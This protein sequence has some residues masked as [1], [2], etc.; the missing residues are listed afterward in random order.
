M[1][2]TVA[3]LIAQVGADLSQ[4]RIGMNEVDAR[5]RLT[6]IRAREADARVANLRARSMV[7]EE[8][9]Q[10]AHQARLTTIARQP[11]LEFARQTAETRLADAQTRLAAAHHAATSTPLGAT[12]R[13][14]T[15]IRREA[16]AATNAEE[17]A[18]TRLQTAT[19]RLTRSQDREMD[20]A[21]R[22][23]ALR[24]ASAESARR[25][26][27]VDE[28]GAA[29]REVARRY[30]ARLAQNAQ[31]HRIR[32]ANAVAAV[33]EKA[34]LI[35]GGGLIVASK[36]GADFNQ[37]LL[38]A[39]HNTSL[40]TAGIDEMNTAVKRLGIESGADMEK[41]ADGFR[42]IENRGYS[43]RQSTEILTQSMKGA[44]A[45]GS[46]LSA[47][48]TLLANVMKEFNIPVSRAADTMGILV[49]ASRRSGV[50]MENLVE[51]F[52]QMSAYSANLGVSLAETAAAFVVFTKHGLNAH[53]AATQFRNDLNKMRNPTPQVQRVL[54]QIKSATGVDVA[55][56]FSPA[57]VR[58]LQPSG[59]LSLVD[60]AAPLFHGGVPAA[61]LIAKLFPLQRGQLGATILTGTGK[62]DYA[63]AIKDIKESAHSGA[64]VNRLY[65]E[66]LKQVNQ[67]LGRLKNAGIVAAGSISTALVPAIQKGIDFI[68]QMAAKFNNLDEAVKS[69]YVKMT[70][71]TAGGLIM[72]G[73][74]AKLIVGIGAMRNALILL[75]LVPEGGFIAALGA[76]APYLLVIGGISVGL[77]LLVKH[78]DDM[79]HAEERMTAD[80]HLHTQV[81]AVQARQHLANATAVSNLTEEWSALRSNI[82]PT[83]VQL[84]RMQ[85]ILNQI[86]ILSPDLISGYD[87]QGRALNMIAEAAGHA[88][89][90][91]HRLAHET[92]LANA[93]AIAQQAQHVGDQRQSL[94]D[95]LNRQRYIVNTNTIP[96]QRLTPASGTDMG[97]P[98]LRRS[99]RIAPFGIGGDS[100]YSIPIFERGTP[101]QISAAASA[102]RRLESELAATNRTTTDLNHNMREAFGH[103]ITRR[104]GAMTGLQRDFA[105]NLQRLID[106]SHGAISAGS[107]YRTTSHQADLFQKELAKI[108]KEHPGLSP[109][110]ADRRARHWVAHGGSSRHNLGMAMDLRFG[111]GGEAFAHRNAA[112]FGLTFPL[113][114][115]N[116]HIEPMGA[117]DM[118]LANVGNVG[119]DGI[120]K[121]KGL[122]DKQKKAREAKEDEISKIRDKMVN[123]M[124]D[125]QHAQFDLNHEGKAGEAIWEVMYGDY[126][127]L[128]YA[129]QALYIARA[130]QTDAMAKEHA[131]AEKL[132]DLNQQHGL[133][134]F[135]A[136]GNKTSGEIEKYKHDHGFYDK[137]YTKEGAEQIVHNARQLDQLKTMVKLDEARVEWSQ[138]LSK[139]FSD[140]TTKTKELYDNEK[141]KAQNFLD[142]FKLSLS[143]EKTPAQIKAIELADKKYQFLSKQQKKDILSPL[144]DAE[145]LKKQDV[146]EQNYDTFASFISDN[147]KQSRHDLLG[148]AD[149]AKQRQ[150][151]FTEQALDR[152]GNSYRTMTQEERGAVNQRINSAFQ[153]IEKNNLEAESVQKITDKLKTIKEETIALTEHTKY[154]VDG[155]KIT[156]TEWNKMTD[157]QHHAILQFLRLKV[158]KDEVGEILNGVSDLFLTTLD[159]IREHGFKSFFIDILQGFDNMLFN[160]A[161]KWAQS[162][163]LQLITNGLGIQIGGTLG[164][165][166]QSP[167]S[168]IT[169]AS[170][171]GIGALAGIFGSVASLGSVG[172]SAISAAG[173]AL[174]STDIGSL[175]GTGLSGLADGGP[176]ALGRS[177]IVGENG[178][179][180]FSPSQSG[181]IIPSGTGGD[182]HMHFHLPNVSDGP[183]FR[184]S[185][186]QVAQSA[187]RALMIAMNNR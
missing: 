92:A 138:L 162:Q 133:D 15:R 175:V 160:I 79:Y 141:E 24:V 112:R 47:T 29:L 166:Q 153:I 163:F 7:Q 102:I 66:S 17:A 131:M 74:L 45:K 159:N 99:G 123:A 2:I 168:A 173:G 96:T 43:A 106:A 55:A 114:H 128:T 165:T 18:V 113:P 115:E 101:A 91:Q 105:D 167:G 13:D 176:V 38:T 143:E 183:A 146:Y 19:D 54:A 12:T 8:A 16:V 147:V 31:E 21:R 35:V 111:P 185:A 71:F 169:A 88:A 132:K 59:V 108:N 180:V 129:E 181:R 157:A 70:A 116:W 84:Q 44:V 124:Q 64:V 95:E 150:A 100:N 117:R 46:D 145:R 158:V 67:Q 149:P 41:L 72:V 11:M 60:Q 186:H 87:A 56:G 119:G 78:Y 109:E 90:E 68:S 130:K 52:G 136:G 177:Y 98:Y 135:E 178:P 75:N 110:E 174:G 80:M 65:E 184:S 22:S 94:I 37:M 32:A 9:A 27:V 139:T 53:E 1:A 10:R 171:L 83:N 48:T 152:L 154:N 76:A 25:A 161:A 61:D 23:N 57:G 77:A 26:T 14:L 144:Q 89:D 164:G 62:S 179:E 4:W 187:A 85:D 121:T 82:H 20:L 50:S 28:E 30:A 58:K 73:V 6:E 182:I 103:D 120:D 134:M 86:S 39:A 125:L 137:D 156:T 63:K 142:E 126:H 69:D 34:G 33:S 81:A 127:R 3:N 93:A 155:I 148:A 118:D 172:G 151:E 122:G 97:N 51:V 5:N 170:G 36:F 140:I 49:E 40:T 42:A 107:G 104:S